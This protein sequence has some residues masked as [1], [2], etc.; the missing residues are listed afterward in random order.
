[1]CVVGNYYSFTWN[2]K[3][4]LSNSNV[5]NIV[6]GM[7]NLKKCGKKEYICCCLPVLTLNCV[8]IRSRCR[9]LLDC[10]CNNKSI[11]IN[12]EYVWIVEEYGKNVKT[13]LY[14]YI[15]STLPKCISVNLLP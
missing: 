12:Q 7:K 10:P 5:H 3:E 15:A 2:I 14:S 1:M 4:F 11:K 8:K 6:E 13:W 9:K